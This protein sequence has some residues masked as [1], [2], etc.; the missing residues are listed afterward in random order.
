MNKLPISRNEGLIFDIQTIK[1]LRLLGIVGY[2]SGTLP[3]STQQNNFLGV[4]LRLLFEELL[5]V[6]VHHSEYYIVPDDVMF[7]GLYASLTNNDL[8]QIRQFAEKEH[9]QRL[10]TKKKEFQAKMSQLRTNGKKIPDSAMIYNTE[11]EPVFHEIKNT[12]SHLPNVNTWNDHFNQPEVQTKLLFQLLQSRP[13]LSHSLA[14][15]LIFSHLR[16]NGYFIT[17]GLRFGGKFV[18]YPGDPLRYHSHLI[19]KPVYNGEKIEL[20]KLVNGGRLATAVKKVYVIAGLTNKIDV[21]GVEPQLELDPKE[22]IT[23]LEAS[24]VKTFSFEWAGFG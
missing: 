19:V 13:N 7:Q 11:K 14:D 12:S 5:Y 16:K 22:F 17:A 3:L 21:D 8:Q 6:V 23:S 24:P 9:N 10:E 4:P 2:L 1:N 18:A 15:Y 20:K